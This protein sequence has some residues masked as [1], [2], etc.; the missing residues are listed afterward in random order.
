MTHD[1]EGDDTGD[2]PPPGPAF[3][4]VALTRYAA[5]QMY[6]PRRLVRE[7]PGILRAPLTDKPVPLVR[8]GA[9]EAMPLVS[10]QAEGLYVTAVKL[11]NATHRPLILDPRGLRGRWL[12]ATFQH[13]RLLPAGD[14]AD[15]TCVYL[16]S[17]RPFE[18]SL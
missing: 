3:G 6:A 18:E 8:G 17:A 16:I 14:P 13:A 4:Y 1:T 5:Q 9:V 12:A 15:T 10:W 2:E 7:P 11:T